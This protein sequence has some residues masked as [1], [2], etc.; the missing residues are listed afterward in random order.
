MISQLFP[1]MRVS[2]SMRIVRVLMLLSQMRT[3]MLILMLTRE[4]LEQIELLC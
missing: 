1:S 4:F 2:Q 3:E